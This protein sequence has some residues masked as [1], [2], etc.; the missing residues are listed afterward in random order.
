MAIYELPQPYP[1]ELETDE[2]TIEL[3]QAI[4][5]YIARMQCE[6]LPLEEALRFEAEEKQDVDTCIADLERQLRPK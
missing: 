5:K 6:R 4:E 1:E 3:R 2:A